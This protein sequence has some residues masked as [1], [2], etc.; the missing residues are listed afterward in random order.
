MKHYIIILLLILGLTSAC[1]TQGV[2]YEYRDTTIEFGSGGGFTG[3]VTE[4]YLDATGNLKKI[5]SLSATETNLGKIKKSNLKK[6]YKSLSELNFAKTDFD[7]PG[8]MYYFI[9]EVNASSVNEV[10]W[11][12]TDNQVPKEIQIFYDLLISSIN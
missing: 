2:L 10:V 5:E 3:Q 9:R 4:Y 8:N 6:I 1:G 11:G 12:S 7:H